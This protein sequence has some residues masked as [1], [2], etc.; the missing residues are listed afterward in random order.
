[1]TG[2]FF[3]TLLFTAVLIALVLVLRRPVARLFGPQAA[4]AL[5]ALPLLRLLLPPIELPA[6]MAPVPESAPPAE[7]LIVYAA[8]VPIPAAEAPIDWASIAI[9]VWAA[10]AVL[11][12]VWRTVTYLR[13][14]RDLLEGAVAVGEAGPVR[15]VECPTVSAPVAFGVRDKVI[16]LP[17]GFMAWHDRRARDLAL[18]HELAH[19]HGHDLLINMLAQPVIALH[20]FNPVA[21]AGW[22]AMRRDQEAACDARVLAG[23]GGE[24]RADYS[25]LIAGLAG[26]PRLALAAPMACPILGEKSI[27]HRL[28]SLSM[29]EPTKTRRRLG[30]GLLI[31]A[32]LAL[33]LTATIG[34][35]APDMPAPPAAP[36]APSAPDAPKVERKVHRVVIVEKHGDGKHGDASLKTRVIERNGKTIIIKTD[37]DLTEAEVEAKIARV[38]ADML[39][40][41]PESPAPPA[42]PGEPRTV[43]KVIV[44]SGDGEH[45]VHG[46]G[47]EGPQVRTMRIHKDGAEA[48]A[49]AMSGVGAPCKDGKPVSSVTSESGKEGQKHIYM[50]RVCGDGDPAMAS[51]HALGGLKSA[52]ARIAG[53]GEMS[54][55]IKAKVLEELDREIARLSKL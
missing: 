42:A 31:G 30:R 23:Q 48:R 45:M 1:M 44:M 7:A 21:W 16:A 33:P 10:G 55:E 8:E 50:V 39:A 28:R 22:R 5:W 11:F 13:M 41:P 17:M 26:G 29:P 36:E 24:V 54:A 34:Y 2:F 27:I 46:P 14:R 6:S 53:N 25:R 12:L 15:L 37:K 51:V 18:A 43:R 49:F 9:A 3:D 20:W 32:A 47:D 35:A 19:H 4:Y 40:M 52:R 38:E